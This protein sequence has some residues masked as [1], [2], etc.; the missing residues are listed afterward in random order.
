MIEGDSGSGSK[1]NGGAGSEI[2]D[3]TLIAQLGNESLFGTAY[4]LVNELGIDLNC[5]ATATYQSASSWGTCP[6]VDR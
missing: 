3:G 4:R 6:V 5:A 1:N 2:A